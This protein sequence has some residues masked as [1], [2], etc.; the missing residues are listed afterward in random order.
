M[1]SRVNTATMHGNMYMA[2]LSL[3]VHNATC[4]CSH[5][6]RVFSG[7]GSTI[8]TAQCTWRDHTTIQQGNHHSW[9]EL[10][11]ESECALFGRSAIPGHSQRL[12]LAMLS[13]HCKVFYIL[14]SIAIERLTLNWCWS[15]TSI[16]SSWPWL[17][18]QA[19]SVCWLSFK[20]YNFNWNIGNVN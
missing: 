16:Q 15:Q 3:T 11:S 2:L 5:T 7:Q 17:W 20:S 12:S 4:I 9:V 18:T 13:Q 19:C 14:T 8:L 6:A 1:Y 10:N